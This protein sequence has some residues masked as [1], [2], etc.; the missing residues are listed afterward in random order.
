[1]LQPTLIAACLLAAAFAAP[2][3]AAGPEA[4]ARYDAARDQYEIG[5][6][7]YAFRT[8]AELADEGHCNAM[9]T[10]LQMARYGRPL[11][12]TEFKIA[13]ERVVAWQRQAHC[14]RLERQLAITR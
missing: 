2:A 7:D 4:A 13:V 12:A 3:R 8:F 14:A 6:Y 1:M 11:Y 5:H 9:R 10:A